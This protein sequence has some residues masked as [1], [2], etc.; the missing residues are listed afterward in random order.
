MYGVDMYY[1][2]KTLSNQGKS[3]LEISKILGI[4]RNTVTKIK[5]IIKNKEPFPTKVSR[6]SSLDA[7]KD[8]ILEYLELD[9]SAVLIHEKLQENYNLN[10]SYGAVRDYVKK[11]KG[12]ECYIPLITP[13]GR[14]GQVDFG[15]V[16]RFKKDGKESKTWTFCMVLSSSRYPYYEFVTNQKTETFIKC[17]INAFEHFGGVPETIKIDNLKSAVLEASF[18][19]PVFQEEYNNFLNHYGTSGVTCRIRR[20]QDKGKVESGIK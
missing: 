5:K 7:Y 6:K 14:E 17:H 18:Y 2:V 10:K 3:N 16:G 13:P 9:L 20:G 4:H 1:S 19:E 15:Y 11:L 12:S 8:K